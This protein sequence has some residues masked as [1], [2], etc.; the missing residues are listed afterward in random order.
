LN[1]KARETQPV[2]PFDVAKAPPTNLVK[3][4]EKFKVRGMGGAK[5]DVAD[6][7][8][9]A[10]SLRRREVLASERKNIVE[11]YRKLMAEKRS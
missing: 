4:K 10:G 7:P 1:R 11:Q 6:V 5:V 2:N 3:P 9:A 8:A